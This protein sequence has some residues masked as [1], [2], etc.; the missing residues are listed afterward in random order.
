MH[1]HCESFSSQ[2]VARY[3]GFQ[4]VAATCNRVG[5]YVTAPLRTCRWD[6]GNIYQSPSGQ[7][8]V[9]QRFGVPAVK[10]AAGLTQEEFAGILVAQLPPVQLPSVASGKEITLGGAIATA[11]H[12][13]IF[14][15]FRWIH[16]FN[17]Y[18][19]LGSLVCEFQNN[20]IMPNVNWTIYYR[21]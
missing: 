21:N 11:S 1:F 17:Q 10:A 15:C 13:G 5:Y 7:S 4:Q 9:F 16:I 19:T 8:P 3:C 6:T 18:Y 20:N 12:V 14:C 2:Q